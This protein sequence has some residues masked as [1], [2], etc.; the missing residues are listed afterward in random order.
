[1]NKTNMLKSLSDYIKKL[2][3]SKNIN[4]PIQNIYN[5]FGYG[6]D[7]EN[8][9]RLLMTLQ[10]YN[11]S[12]EIPFLATGQSG[13]FNEQIE[14]K[15]L[16]SLQINNEDIE[17]AQYIANCFGVKTN[18][19]NSNIPITYTTLLGTT[20]FNYATQS[21]PAI[22]FEDVFQCS[23]SHSLPIQPIVGESEQ[24]YYLRLLKH[25]ISNTPTFNKNNEQ[26]ALLRAKRLIANFCKHKNR[27]Y[28]IKLDEVLQTKASFGDIEGLRDRRISYEESLAKIRELSS[29]S[30]LMTKYNI[31]P[32]LVY[33]DPNMTSEYGIA[34]YGGIPKEKTTYIEV[35]RSYQ[36]MQRKALDMGLQ[37][38]VEIPP[39][40]NNSFSK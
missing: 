29:L 26:E 39:S 23:P 14:E 22:I 11:Q 8:D 5:Q 27:V 30:D 13:Y 24:D 37:V 7:E 36:M 15:G 38:G 25:Q 9:A 21:F 35:E 12:Q 2:K 1:M 31:Q 10:E 20:E 6:Y 33:F 3:I 28:L 40:Y 4:I 18:F 32:N 17:D 34:L 19:Q 16:T